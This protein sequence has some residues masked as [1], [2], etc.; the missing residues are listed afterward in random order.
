MVELHSIFND[1]DK[2]WNNDRADGFIRE[3]VQY[4]RSEP[5]AA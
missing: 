2:G 5:A 3:S 1:N 4:V